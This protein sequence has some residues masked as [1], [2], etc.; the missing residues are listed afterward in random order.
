MKKVNIGFI[1]LRLTNNSLK[2]GISMGN[3]GNNPRIRKDTLKVMAN[4]EKQ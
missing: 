4:G 3:G 1:L 2:W